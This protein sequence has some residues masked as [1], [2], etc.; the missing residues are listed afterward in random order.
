MYW[1]DGGHKG[2]ALP[3]DQHPV[4]K[5]DEGGHFYAQDLPTGDCIFVA[6]CVAYGSGILG[7]RTSQG[8]NVTLP[9]PEGQQGVM[10]QYPYSRKAFVQIRGTVVAG[11]DKRPLRGHRIVLLDPGSSGKRF[12]ME[13]DTDRDGRFRFSWVPPGKYAL[14]IPGT[15]GRLDDGYKIENPLPAGADIDAEVGVQKRPAGGPRHAATVRCVDDADAPV[16]EAEVAFRATN[17]HSLPV[18]TGADGVARA[19]GFPVPLIGAMATRPGHLTFAGP[20]E[21]KEG[22][23]PEGLFVLRRLAT[24]RVI[25]VDD[26]TG[27]TLRRAR[28]AVEHAGG[29]EDNVDELLRPPKVMT[30]DGGFD[31][32]VVP[33]PVTIRAACPGYLVGELQVEVPGGGMQCPATVRLAPRAP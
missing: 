4:A 20:L 33:G 7:A 17:F 16:A 32:R 15:L 25:V 9:L 14:G 5:T 11:E 19:E 2:P 10:L 3:I 21:P 6:D 31:V 18:L 13:A 22:G 1:L 28:L 29:M 12:R 30:A 27:E 26:A 24:V 23:S 8:L